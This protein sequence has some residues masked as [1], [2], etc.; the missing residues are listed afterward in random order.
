[1]KITLKDTKKGIMRVVPQNQDDLWL[2]SQIISS[3]ALI[4]AKTTR[5]I[6]IS[7]T[8]VEK[9]TYFLSIQIEKIIYENDVLRVSGSVMSENDDI[10]K[11][12]A[13]SISIEINDTVKIEQKWLSFQ[14]DKL[15][16]ATKDKANILLVV[17]DREDVYFAQLTQENYRVLSNFEG[18]VERKMEGASHKGNFYAEVTEKMKEYNKRLCLDKIVV[19]SPAFFKDDFMKQ[20]NDDG[21]KKKIILATCSSV[22]EN[23]FAELIK[24]EEVKQ[25]LQDERVREELELV[26]QLFVEISKDGKC[27]Y[28]LNVVKEKVE[29]GAAETL[30]ISTDAINDYREKE[31]FNVLEKMMVMVEQMNGKIVIITSTNE[32]GKKLDGITGIG[33][34]LRY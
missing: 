24:R 33:A 34:I 27:A 6:M 32:A 26:D 15:E 11:G 9:K 13:H 31:K 12:S 7:E 16:D 20:L 25:A 14:L 5:K 4:S 10:P 2:L 8:I 17:L 29:S 1:M 30:L 18:E 21:L 3:G 22:S 19:A 23:A 28:G